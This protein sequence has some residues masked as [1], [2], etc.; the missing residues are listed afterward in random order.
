[1]TDPLENRQSILLDH[2][3][4][5]RDPNPQAAGHVKSMPG[6]DQLPHLSLTTRR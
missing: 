3:D 6:S 4:P 5:V 2:G 1:M